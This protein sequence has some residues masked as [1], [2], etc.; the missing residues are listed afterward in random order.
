MRGSC[1]SGLMSENRYPSTASGVTPRPVRRGSGTTAS[2]G[3]GDPDVASRLPANSPIW[4]SFLNSPPATAL[5]AGKLPGQEVGTVD[6]F[7]ASL[8]QGDAA[9]GLSAALR[10]THSEADFWAFDPFEV[11]SY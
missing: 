4:A 6:R 5:S 11:M 3:W 2:G 10:R 9:F 8:H 7:F 1:D